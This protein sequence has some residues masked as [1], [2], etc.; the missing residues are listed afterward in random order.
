MEDLERGCEN[1]G[2][3]AR[4]VRRGK[5]YTDGQALIVARSLVASL[6]AQ[7]NDL[8]MVLKSIEGD[9]RHE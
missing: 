9:I 8:E 1:V 3:T 6:R 4:T 7:A 2:E 5:N